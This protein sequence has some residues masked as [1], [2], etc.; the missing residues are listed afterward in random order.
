MG[1]RMLT[2]GSD[3]AFLREAAAAALAAVRG[4]HDEPG[5]TEAPAL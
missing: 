2:A 4:E 3:G 1:Y 5:A